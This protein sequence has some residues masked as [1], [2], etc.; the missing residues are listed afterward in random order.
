MPDVMGHRTQSLAE[1]ER[2]TLIRQILL[3]MEK[4]EKKGQRQKV[5]FYREVLANVRGHAHA[6][7]VIEAARTVEYAILNRAS[8]QVLKNAQDRLTAQI[9]QYDV[10]VR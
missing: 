6:I 5:K 1:Q 8:P 9:H 3:K 2:E 4:A 7:P 10:R